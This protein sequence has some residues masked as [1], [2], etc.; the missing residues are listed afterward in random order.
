MRSIALGL[1]ILLTACSGGG[2]STIGGGQPGLSVAQAALRGGAPLIALQVVG[3]LLAK[4]P[5]NDDA[6]VIQGEALTQLGRLDE[7]ASS[8]STVL[9][10]DP[11]SVGAHIGL[12]RVRLAS[13]P[14]TAEVLFLE[15]LQREPRN[16]VALNNLGIARDLQGHHADAQ[17]AYREAMAANP[18]MTAARV[19]L[20]L[21][22]AM[23]GQPRDAVQLLRPLASDAGASRQVRHDLAA[24]LTM[25]GDKA[26]A[27]A[28]LSKD[29]SADE[30]RQAMD[31]YG[32]GRAFMSSGLP[33]AA[34][35]SRDSASR[36]S[37]RDSVQRAPPPADPAPV[38]ASLPVAVTPGSSAVASASVP[39]TPASMGSAPT[40][41]APASEPA[42]MQES[43][44]SGAPLVQLAAAVS[45]DAAQ[46]EWRR[47]QQHMPD[48]MD[49][50][51]PIIARVER[52]GQSFWRLRVGGFADAGQASAFCERLHAGGGACVVTR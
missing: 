22:L 15:A 30:V 44:T 41:V 35:S 17:T 12:G 14:A 11:A 23:Q 42:A 37:P 38:A 48:V 34:P 25:N 28:I 51:Q 10:H 31:A 33:A 52:N 47:L 4:N 26:E 36:E 27:T 24:V 20:A 29:M 1:L 9:Q 32:N 8:F 49:G 6:L 5:G 18:S 7:A 3:T 45:A 46:A 2:V 19:N 13:D 16:A 40:P 50:R 43:A 39:V 21:S